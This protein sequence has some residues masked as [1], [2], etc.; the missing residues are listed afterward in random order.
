[1]SVGPDLPPILGVE[2]EIRDALMNLILNA[3]DA[4]PE[5]GTLALRSYTVTQ[6]IVELNESEK[7]QGPGLHAEAR[8]CTRVRVDVCD[9]GV[10]MTE[11][12]RRKCLQP[13]YTTKGEGGTGLGLAMVY[14]MVQRHRAEI[15]IQSAPHKG[16][17]ISLIFQV[18]A[19]TSSSAAQPVARPP[20]QS[21]RILVVD[22]DPHVLKSFRRILESDGHRVTTADGGQ[23]GI[24]TFIAATQRGE[25]FALVIADLGMP[26]V[27]GRKVAAAIKTLSPRTPIVLVTGWGDSISAAG[28][29]PLHVDRLLSKPPDIEAFRAAI[30]DLT[31]KAAT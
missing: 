1:M 13:F 17:T 30:F 6:P 29:L 19:A 25:S 3:V 8:P 18:A 31:A 10:G 11:E 2:G 7:H 28:E 4:M 22:D 26:Y 24:D 16:T 15:E 9:T 14:G 21:L 12:T 23:A 27:D 20:T 5:G